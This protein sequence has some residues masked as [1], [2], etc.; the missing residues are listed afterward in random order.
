MEEPTPTEAMVP[1]PVPLREEAVAPALPV[2]PFVPEAPAM[3]EPVYMPL[4]Q[5]TQMPAF[6]TKME[7]F[8]PELARRL[9][10]EG[11]VIL[12]LNISEEGEVLK[13]EVVKGVGFGFDEAARDAIERSSFEPARVGDRPVAVVVRIPIRFRFKD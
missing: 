4:V 1:L 12:E 9:E 2:A 6:K 13:V 10:K 11:T 8:Y 7:P 3:K 5:V